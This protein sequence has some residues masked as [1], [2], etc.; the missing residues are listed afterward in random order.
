MERFWEAL[1]DGDTKVVAQMLGEHPELLHERDAYDRIPLMV[2][3][4]S[5]D[6]E[7]A[8]VELLICAGAEVNAKT[9]EVYTPLHCAVDVDGPTCRG[10]MPSQIIQLLVKA[11]AKLEER[12]H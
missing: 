2:A 11:G 4:G 9:S 3:V 12:Q 8:C 6:R 10:E 1:A 5:M 7:V